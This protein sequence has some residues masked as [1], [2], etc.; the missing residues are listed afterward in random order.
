MAACIALAVTALVAAIVVITASPKEPR[1]RGKPLTA[2][3]RA[4]QGNDLDFSADRYAEPREALR[5]L[6]TNAIPY[7]SY[8][9]AT[10]D[11][12][13]KLAIIRGL[14]KQSFFRFEFKDADLAHRLA[15]RGFAAM[16][17]LAASAI[18]LLEKEML[19]GD[20]LPA[21]EALREMG[22][23]AYP[24]LERALTN[25]SGEVRVS[26]LAALLVQTN[27]LEEI[28]AILKRTLKSNFDKDI[29]LSAALKLAEGGTDGE[30]I[31]PV[32][33]DGLESSEDDAQADSARALL[34]Y[35]SEAR[36]HLAK[37]HRMAHDPNPIINHAA[38]EVLNM[39]ETSRTNSSLRSLLVSPASTLLTEL[40]MSRLLLLL[41][42]RSR[43]T[44][45]AGSGGRANSAVTACALSIPGSAKNHK[46]IPGLNAQSSRRCINGSRR[47]WSF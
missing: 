23:V 19:N 6:H 17:S 4:L 15:L 41:N 35:P 31:V 10:R 12:R 3:L 40:A 32:L 28:R 27:H 5:A 20:H 2:W 46:F 13:F 38:L 22:P 45:P 44:V 30:I 33:L 9:L 14:R 18:P 7:L 8:M 47:A 36:R 29:R 11:S 42:L 26:A 16:G 39:L 25:I 24:T 37:F 1:S 43:S 21:S 34:Y